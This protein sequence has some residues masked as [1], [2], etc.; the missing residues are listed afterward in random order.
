M[1][2]T[3]SVITPINTSINNTNLIKMQCKKLYITTNPNA[4]YSELP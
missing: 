2:M 1:I 3:Q 4:N